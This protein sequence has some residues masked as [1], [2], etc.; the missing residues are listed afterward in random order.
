MRISQVNLSVAA[1]FLRAEPEDID[2]FK[3]MKDAAEAYITG[4][5]GLSAEECDEHED[6]CVALL[7][8]IG[9]MYENRTITV[10]SDKQNPL[11]AQ[12]LAMHSENYV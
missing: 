8:L 11:V 5:T 10:D 2:S 7:V 6:L 12:I 9:E 4:F 1:E 3:I